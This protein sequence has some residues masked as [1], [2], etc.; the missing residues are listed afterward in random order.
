[1]RYQFHCAFSAFQAARAPHAFI[2][3]SVKR[4]SVFIIPVMATVMIVMVVVIMPV[5]STVVTILITV[6]M[7]MPASSEIQ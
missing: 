6:S 3:A 7:A 4:S 5:L 1:M 2:N